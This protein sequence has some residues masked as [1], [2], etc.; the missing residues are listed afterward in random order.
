MDIKFRYTYGGHDLPVI[1]EELLEQDD[2]IY[3]YNHCNE[4]EAV[5][6]KYRYTGERQ[7]YKNMET[8]KLFWNTSLRQDD[9]GVYLVV[10]SGGKRG[11]P[12][13]VIK[14]Y[15][16]VELFPMPDQPGPDYSYCENCNAWYSNALIKTDY[17]AYRYNNA[18]SSVTMCPSGH[19]INTTTSGQFGQK[20]GT[21][22][23]EED[24]GYS[25]WWD[26]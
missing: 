9:H 6:N 15:L 13:R 10:D 17:K 19:V 7:R 5:M 18:S 1:K 11:Y 21:P 16:A 14:Y 24:D 4:L 12:L 3:D 26:G 2:S 22:A 8:G 23:R 25:D 20:G